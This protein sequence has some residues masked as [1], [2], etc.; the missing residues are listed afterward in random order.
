MAT[1]KFLEQELIRKDQEIERLQEENESIR[2]Y[3]QELLKNAVGANYE[4]YLIGYDFEQYVVRWM[5]EYYN[6]KYSLISWQSDKSTISH[7]THERLRAKWNSVPDLVYFD[8]KHQ[9]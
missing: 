1:K 4:N 2:Q 6:N 8:K 7:I 3:Y 9:K 5:D